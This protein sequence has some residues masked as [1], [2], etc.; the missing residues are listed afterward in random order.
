MLCNTGTARRDKSVVEHSTKGCKCSML[1][2]AG[3]TTQAGI[4]VLHGTRHCV[5]VATACKLL[6]FGR[7]FDYN[8][9]NLTSASACLLAAPCSV[10]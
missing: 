8:H 4:N 10:H 3:V 5:W 2:A 7:C 1:A 6:S 9:I